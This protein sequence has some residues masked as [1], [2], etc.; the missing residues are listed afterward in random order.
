MPVPFPRGELPFLQAS[1]LST[2]TRSRR[3]ALWTLVLA[4]CCALLL[5]GCHVWSAHRVLGQAREEL[6][7]AEQ[8]DLAGESLYHRVVAQ[9]LIQAAQKQYEDADFPEADRFAQ[10]ALRHLSRIPG[11]SAQPS[12]DSSSSDASE[13]SP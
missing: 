10:E 9:E 7:R 1:G 3:K 12:A 11:G 8:M 5:S 13:A 6:A 4:L 2:E